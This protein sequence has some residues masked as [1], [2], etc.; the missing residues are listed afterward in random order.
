MFSLKGPKTEIEEEKSKN[1]AIL[2]QVLG[3]RIFKT[4]RTDP[5]NEHRKKSQQTDKRYSGKGPAVA[6][7]TFNS[8]LT[9]RFDPTKEESKMYEIEDASTKKRKVNIDFDK[10]DQ[11]EEQQKK[12]KK[13]KTK[14]EPATTALKT[15]DVQKDSSAAQNPANQ[16]ENYYEVSTNLKDTLAGGEDFSI[17]SFLGLS[18]FEE[19]SKAAAFANENATF[20]PISAEER[21]KLNQL[22]N[23]FKYDSSDDE[24]DTGRKTKWNDQDE[25][26]QE[27]GQGYGD[28]EMEAEEDRVQIKVA[29]RPQLLAAFSGFFFRPDDTRLKMDLFYA[30]E[31]IE[32][33]RNGG[34]ERSLAMMHGLSFRK[35][36]AQKNLKSDEKFT[37]KRKMMR[38][39]NKGKKG[40]RRNFRR[41]PRFNSDRNQ[42][43]N[44][45]PTGEGPTSKPMKLAVS[46]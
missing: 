14:K 39:M 21:K 11:L 9:P 29:P 40:H 24:E 12:K 19:P 20:E 36:A 7:A 46:S 2:E 10:L 4:T 1:L 8:V 33:A 37:K 42:Q 43:G 27:D 44:P 45:K 25:L 31:L 5:V 38:K 28:D 26:F 23:P 18:A 17:G 22:R 34:K 13:T 41:N 35:R 15:K 32:K 16:I 30:P 3:K 6:T